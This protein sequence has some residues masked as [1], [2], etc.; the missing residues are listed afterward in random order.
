MDDTKKLEQALNSLNLQDTLALMNLLN[1]KALW[2]YQEEQKTKKIIP[3]TKPKL[4]L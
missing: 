2:M 1:Q 3:V 4:I